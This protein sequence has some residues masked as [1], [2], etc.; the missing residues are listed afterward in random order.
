M[1]GFAATY[2]PIKSRRALLC[3]AIEILKKK[4]ML[5]TAQV[6]RQAI[7]QAPKT[8]GTKAEE[9]EI[10]AFI[11]SHLLAWLMVGSLGIRLALLTL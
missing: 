6:A 5:T 11:D 1:K 7:V 9:A 8:V 2:A 4:P 3:A 10:A